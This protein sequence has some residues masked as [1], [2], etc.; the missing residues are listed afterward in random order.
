MKHTLPFDVNDYALKNGRHRSV[1]RELFEYGQAKRREIGA[2]NIFDYSL[3]N[4]S[5]PPPA[6]VT[7]AF[8]RLIRE[9][10]PKMLHGYTSNAGD[11]G[12]R[13][14][15]ADD[16]NRRFGTSYRGEHLFMTCG[17]AAALTCTLRA[18]TTDDTQNTF[19][20][21]APY[22]PEYKFF[23]EG[24]GAQFKAV[25]AQEPDFGPSVEAL[26]PLLDQHTRGVLI[27]SPNNPTGRLYSEE[28]LRMLS[29]LLMRKSRAWGHPIFLITDEPYRELVYDGKSAPHIPSIYPY[30]IMCYSYS[31]SLS[32]PGDRIGYV[33]VPPQFEDHRK[34]FDAIAGAA[35]IM[36]YVCAP[37]LL[38]H[39]VAATVG[40]HQNLDHYDENRRLL[41]DGLNAFG[42]QS[43]RPEGAFYLFT[44]VPGGDDIR[45][46]DFLRDHYRILAVPSQS[47]GCDGYVRLSYCVTREMI[48]RSLPLFARALTEYKG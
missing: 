35:R 44:Q 3:G 2:E 46:S 33:L 12:V 29:D 8:I 16:L 4:P 39:V 37:A 27:N 30:T 40:V 13:K 5:V 42:Y 36:G 21:F 11:P 43:V 31:K 1:I 47:F 26:E 22:F 15:L 18:L 6:E 7:N 20:A 45:F 24:Q 34:V 38:Q 9:M 19:V 41:Y 23:T 25:P 32:I 48:E 14:T 10:N 28:E 17:A